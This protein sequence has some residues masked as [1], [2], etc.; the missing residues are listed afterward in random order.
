MFEDKFK[1]N[2]IRRNA[3]KDRNTELQG[4]KDESV[5]E[6]KK[7]MKL[8]ERKSNIRCT[9]NVCYCI[10]PFDCVEKLL[11]CDAWNGDIED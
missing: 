1:I 10:I 4:N 8:R 3:Q 6:K 7:I 2:S 9:N 11:S 5:E